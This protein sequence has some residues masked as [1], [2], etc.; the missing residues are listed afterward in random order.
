M[1]ACKKHMSCQ[2]IWSAPF[3]FPLPS[4]LPHD[5]M[6]SMAPCGMTNRSMP[7]VGL[8]V[9]R[10]HFTFL[11]CKIQ[12]SSKHFCDGDSVARQRHGLVVGQRSRG[13]GDLGTCKRIAH[14]LATKRKI[15]G[16]LA[17]NVRDPWPSSCRRG[18]RD[19]VR[20]GAFLHALKLNF[21]LLHLLH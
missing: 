11:K 5:G 2:A 8:L 21:R 3:P 7:F 17:K 13:I 12:L 18:F 14:G 1:P 15:R 9:A 6:R 4:P 19:L 16:P 10:E 20:A